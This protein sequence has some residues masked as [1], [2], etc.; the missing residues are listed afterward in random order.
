M[1]DQ[2]NATDHPDFEHHTFKRCDF[3]Y[4][5]E[6]CE[7]ETCTHEFC[8]DGGHYPTEYWST[9]DTIEM[10]VDLGFF[11]QEDADAMGVCPGCFGA[12]EKA[13][14]DSGHLCGNCEPCLPGFGRFEKGA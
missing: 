12:A 13:V 3:D 10:L 4:L 14:L 1:A 11:T 6:R 8:E 9:L 7:D 5:E 2:R